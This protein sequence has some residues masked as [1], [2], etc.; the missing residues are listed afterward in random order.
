MMKGHLEF[1][2][3]KHEVSMRAFIQAMKDEN[4]PFGIN[5][6]GSYGMENTYQQWI[7]R[8]SLYC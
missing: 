2:A 4:N 3:I 6:A 5:G 8:V 7:V 1:P